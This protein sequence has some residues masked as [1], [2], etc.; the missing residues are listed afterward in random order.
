MK[1]WLKRIA[2]A[3]GVLVALGTT[4]SLWLQYTQSGAR[5]ALA[6][7]QGALD[8]KLAIADVSGTLSG[9]LF[10]SGLRYRDA[11]TGVDAVKV[12]SAIR[13]GAAAGQRAAF[14]KR[15]H[16]LRVTSRWRPFRRRPLAAATPLHQLLTP[17][18]SSRSTACAWDERRRDAKSFRCSCS[19]ASSCPQTG[20][21]PVSRSA[22]S[23]CPRLMD[24]ST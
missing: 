24:A 18:L 16:R 13:A 20:R 17:P 7:V 23:R 8:G 5:F 21:A 2:I 15:R 9:P 11:K 22:S 10:L 6:R 19:T 4:F 14:R 3:L 1:K 12:E